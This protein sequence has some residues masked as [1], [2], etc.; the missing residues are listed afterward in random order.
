MTMRD[1]VSAAT[2]LSL[3]GFLGAA[4][5]QHQIAFLAESIL[6]KWADRT[7]EEACQ[8]TPLLD[9][10]QGCHGYLFSKLFCS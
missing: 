1:V 3:V 4:A 10:V 8:T 5:L 6:K 9:T 7:V 2:M